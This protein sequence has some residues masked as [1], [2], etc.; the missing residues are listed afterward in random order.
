MTTSKPNVTLIPR[1]GRSASVDEA[2]ITKEAAIV[3]GE[4]T[5][6]FE[7]PPENE[8]EEPRIFRVYSKSAGQLALIDAARLRYLYALD[9]YQIGGNRLWKWKR[10][11]HLL[12]DRR[13]DKILV[14]RLELLQTI[15]ADMYAKDR[16]QD[17]TARDLLTMPHDVFLAILKAHREANDVSDILAVLIP[18]ST[19]SEEKKSS[20]TLRSGWRT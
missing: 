14:A 9:K 11:Y 20:E 15:F 4:P 5:A 3:F 2:A 6:T 10:L 1:G 19:D 18:A 17:V 13:L 7:L 12:L 8:D 16:H